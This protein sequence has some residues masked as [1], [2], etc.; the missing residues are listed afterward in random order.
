VNAKKPS[1]LVWLYNEQNRYFRRDT[2]YTFVSDQASWR[3]IEP[4]YIFR[5]CGQAS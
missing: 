1:K 2:A 5:V 3:Q 4:A